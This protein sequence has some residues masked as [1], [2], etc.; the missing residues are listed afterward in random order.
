MTTELNKT[1]FDKFGALL[2]YAN[3]LKLMKSHGVKTTLPK[4]TKV[5]TVSDAAYRNFLRQLS[6]V[7]MQKEIGV[8]DLEKFPMSLSIIGKCLKKKSDIPYE[9]L[10]KAMSEYNNEGILAN[11]A[12]LMKLLQIS[13][14]GLYINTGDGGYSQINDIIIYKRS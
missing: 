12:Y 9:V 14:K 7:N 8:I 4:E 13:P 11:Y 2:E 6:D 3:F 5:S 1:G 10:A